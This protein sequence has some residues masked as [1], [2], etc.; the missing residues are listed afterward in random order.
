[1][2]KLLAVTL[3][4]TGCATMQP[5]PKT[6]TIPISVPCIKELPVKPIFATH[7]YLKGLSV[8]DYPLQVTAELLK[9]ENYSSEL[10]SVLIACK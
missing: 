9:Y 2:M 8:T 5:I 3:L 6:V 4:L 10:E 7:D 1:M